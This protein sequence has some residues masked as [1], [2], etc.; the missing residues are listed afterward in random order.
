MPM[1]VMTA[2][3]KG[4]QFLGVENISTCLTNN[5]SQ[6]ALNAFALRFQ[7]NFLTCLY[8]TVRR[9]PGKRGPKTSGMW[10]IIVQK[11]RS[12]VTL[13]QKGFGRTT[14]NSQIFLIA[15]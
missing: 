8:S 1:Q 3:G 10:R 5:S 9:N 11:E 6:R 2:S 15:H 4:A 12:S 13:C 7:P 14:P